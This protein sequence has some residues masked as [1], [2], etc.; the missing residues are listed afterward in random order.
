MTGTIELV[1]FAATDAVDTDWTAKLCDVDEAGHSI[2]LCDGIIRAR[3][4]DSLEHPTLLE[5][6]RVYE[7][8]FRVGSTANLFRQGHRIRLEISSSNFPMFDI[9]TNTG[10][11]SKDATV[12]ES[13]VATQAIFHDGERPSRLLIPFV[14]R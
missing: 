5:P 7:Y 12:L 10:N 4:R 13:K 9:N 6:D 1:L 8:R 3:Y 11:R 14:D 2:N